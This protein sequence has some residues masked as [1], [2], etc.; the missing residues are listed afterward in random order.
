MKS[1]VITWTVAVAVLLLS[2]PAPAAEKVSYL[3]PAPAF[4]PAFAPWAIAKQRGYYEKEGLEVELQTARGGVDVAKQVGAGNAPVG[5]AIGDTPLIVR[6]NDIA[7]KAVAV[8]GGGSLA[9]LAY[10]KESGIT[11][12]KDL[13][14]KVV[15]VLSYQDTTYY[16]LLGMLASVGLSKNDLKVEAAGPANSWKLWAAGKADAI[17]ISPDIVAQGIASGLKN[18]TIEPLDQYFRSMAQ[19]IVASDQIIKERPALIK[20][21]VQATLR[22]MK[23]IMDDPKS[24][25]DDFVKA[26]PQQAEHR[27]W[28]EDSMRLYNKYVYAGQ[29]KLGVMDEGRLAALQKFYVE[30]GIVPKALPIREHFTNQFVE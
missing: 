22:G 7:V 8:L 15:T 13:K 17:V 10:T 23:D 29:P 21:L 14:G 19:A 20:G 27:Q 16:A 25:A 11:G 24:A 5:G 12:P 3:L 30:Q 4:L 2:P 1:R 18:V 6:P 28:V 9:V 26:F